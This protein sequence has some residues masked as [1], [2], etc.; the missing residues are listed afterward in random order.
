MLAACAAM[1]LTGCVAARTDGPA[2]VP[3]PAATG[4]AADEARI[5]DL[6]SRMSLEH[7]V[8]QL[9]QPQINSFTAADMER[10]R[11]GSFLNGGNGGPYGDEFA[12]ASQWLKLAD[13]MWTASARPLPGGEPVVPTLWG[14]D[15]VHG[16][17]NVVGATIF[18][19]NVALGATHDPDVVRRIGEATA[20]EILATGIDWDFSPTVAV[21]RDQ[22]WGRSYESYSQDPQLV[23][24]LGAAMVEGLQGT[25]GSAGWLRDGHVIATAK[26]FFADGGT[27]D[28][29][30]QGDAVGDL[31]AIEA[32]HTVPYRAAIDAG[33]E[34]VMVSFSSINGVKMTGNKSLL[35]DLLR[36][37]MGFGGMTVGDWNAHGQV[38]GC[39]V[40]DCP[41][42]VLAGLDM[43]MVPDDWKALHASL[44]AQ[45]RDGTVPMARLDQAVARVL[46]MKLHAG[47]LLPEAKRPIERPLAGKFELL[48]SPEHRA[49]AREAVAKSQVVLKNDGVLPL[50]AGAKVLVAGAEA[51][52]IGAAAGGWTLTWQGGLDLKRSLFPGA[53]SIWAG[54]RDA[55]AGKGGT[56]TYSADGSFSARPDVAVVVFG[57]APYAEFAGD[58]HD[59]VLRDEEG[60]KLLKK[61]RAAGIPTVSVF[62]SGRPLWTNREMN[63]SNAFVASWLPGSEGMGVADVLTGARP[64]T[65]RLAFPWP[66]DCAGGPAGAVLFPLGAGRD[67]ADRTPTPLLPE[68]CAALSAF[69]SSAMF[70]SGKLATGVA[71]FVPKHDVS[72]DGELL[73]GMRGDLTDAG[74]SVR[75]IDKDA[76]EDAREIRMAAGSA[77][78]LRQDRD[79]GGAYRIVYAVMTR[80]A[81]PVSLRVGDK[82][83]V[84]LTD[85]FA[86]AEGKGWREMVITEACAPGLGSRIRFDTK[87]PLTFR[88]ASVRREKLPAGTPCAF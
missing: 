27:K 86:L 64:A 87:G 28:G 63:L 70:V 7:K 81:A 5:A 33:V 6:L 56:A 9:I 16:H 32:I 35:T 80:P 24:R 66:A 57:E 76:Q 73:A 88:I 78:G 20:Q 39:K 69:D 55:V 22:R 38:D 18:P 30:D 10:Y 71:A 59:L 15:A 14:T 1:A 26:H 72:G 19:Q 49:V 29:V 8:S 25:K 50:R 37:Q 40:S 34:T 79:S 23:A 74:V 52:N 48:G 13:E 61:F 68:A 43:Y 60:L 44:V 17:T 65:G 85:K 21:S 41:K 31:A 12:P 51:D 36:G 4:A 45:V 84:D 42:A 67:L 58:R 46:R 82:A 62:L 53:T 75:G 83:V 2:S 47:L 3:P 54:L 77:F 11:F